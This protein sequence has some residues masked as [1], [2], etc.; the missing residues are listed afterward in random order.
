MVG[1][2][3]GGWLV[4]YLADEEEVSLGNGAVGLQEVRLEV[5]IKEVAGHACWV[6][7]WVGGW[8]NA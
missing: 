5:D 8:V 4:R 3:V 6:E 7:R 2:W 1:G